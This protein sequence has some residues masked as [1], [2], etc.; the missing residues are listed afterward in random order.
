MLFPGS[1]AMSILEE[2]HAGIV[3]SSAEETRRLGARF[4]ATLQPD[5]TLALHGDLGVG[6][7]TFVQGLAQGFSLPSAVTSPTFNILHLYRAPI[8]AP[9]ARTLAHLDAYRIENPHQI[10]EL[11]LDDILISPYCLAVEWPDRIAAWL[12]ADTLHLT[13]AIEAPG[14][15]SVKLL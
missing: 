10:A 14:R 5:V 7:T 11:M 2:L 6:K 1:A 15:H 3:T 8:P 4:A 12:P 9:E 13:L